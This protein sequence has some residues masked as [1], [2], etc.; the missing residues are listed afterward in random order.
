[1]KLFR[2]NRISRRK[3]FYRAAANYVHEDCTSA[4]EGQSSLPVILS[5]SSPSWVIVARAEPRQELRSIERSFWDSSAFRRS[6]NVR[7]L[8]QVK[9]GF[10]MHTSVCSGF[11]LASCSKA[12]SI[13]SNIAPS[14]AKEGRI[15]SHKPQR[16]INLACALLCGPG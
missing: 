14:R 15:M 16:F 7:D 11:L 6:Y 3:S 12:M 1:M 9:I 10:R 2:Q 8:R 13:L 5:A 4:R